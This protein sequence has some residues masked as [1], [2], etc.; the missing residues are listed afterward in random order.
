MA[1]AKKTAGKEKKVRKAETAILRQYLAAASLKAQ[2]AP[3][4]DRKS[5]V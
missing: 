3:K 2:Q 1:T 5:V 4:T